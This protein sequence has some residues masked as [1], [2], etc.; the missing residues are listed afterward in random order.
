VGNDFAARGGGL[1]ELQAGNRDEVPAI[2]MTAGPVQQEIFNG[3][4]PQP[5]QL[6]GAF[7]PNARQGRDWP[8]EGRGLLCW[9]WGSHRGPA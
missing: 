2:F 4:N 5:A 7:R 3:D 8:G 9:R 6:R 1:I